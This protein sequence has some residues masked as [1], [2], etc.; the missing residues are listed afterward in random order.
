STVAP[1][2]FV[3]YNG[4]AG[5]RPLQAGEYVSSLTA[6]GTLNNVRLTAG[7]TLTQDQTI[8]ALHYNS[9]TAGTIDLSNHNL[10]VNSGAIL[11]TGNL[12]FTG[13]TLNFGSAEGIIHVSLAGGAANTNVTINSVITGS[14]G[15][16]SNTSLL[17]LNGV[18]QYT[19][20]TTLNAGGVFFNNASAFGTGP[21]AIRFRNWTG[22]G[23]RS[24]RARP[25]SNSQP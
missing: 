4:T 24:T 5:V 13:G 22:G 3:T 9:N 23:G 12:T 20:P 16:T 15:L 19:G 6:P 17:T 25:G 7:T 10:T 11:A 2:S 8:N 21:E 18:N 1:L 14:G